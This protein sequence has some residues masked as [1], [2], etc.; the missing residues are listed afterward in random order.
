MRG[1]AFKR[2]ADPAPERNTEASD[3]ANQRDRSLLYC[4]SAE[5]AVCWSTIDARYA[6][7]RRDARYWPAKVCMAT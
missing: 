2:A 1:N 6:A 4:P 7:A 5:F 3:R